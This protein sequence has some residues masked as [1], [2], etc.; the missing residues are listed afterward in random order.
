MIFHMIRASIAKNPYMLWFFKG[1]G[2]LDPLSP[3]SSESE[4]P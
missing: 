1:G 3:P 2:G 4:Y